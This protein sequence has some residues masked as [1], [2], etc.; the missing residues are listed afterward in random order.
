[1]E[2]RPL[3]TTYF[4]LLVAFSMVVLGYS[5]WTLYRGILS[6]KEDPE[7]FY[8][9]AFI[10]LV[11]IML[12]ASS[13]IQIRRRLSL[14]AR[15][16]MKVLTVTM[17]DGCSLKAIRDFA[18]GDYVYKEV[19]KCQQCSGPTYISQIYQEEPKRSPRASL[20]P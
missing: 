18:A 4:Y 12:A 3:G 17:C 1:M 6:M 11:G 10:S 5:I 19:G 7:G 16:A 8:Y 14:A 20:A 2:R 9:N 13:V 15:S